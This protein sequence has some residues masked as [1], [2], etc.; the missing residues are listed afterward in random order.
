MVEK[1]VHRGKKK[2]TITGKNFAFCIAQSNDS[3]VYE[4]DSAIC[5]IDGHAKWYRFK[6]A[7]TIAR[8]IAQERLG[9]C[10]GAF[11]GVIWDEKSF[12][13]SGTILE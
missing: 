6:G 8:S 10:K 11:A 4:S 13:Y 12:T 3:D 1:L 9:D 2:R 7:E 5:L